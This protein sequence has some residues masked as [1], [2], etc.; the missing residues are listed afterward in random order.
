M[1]KNID[2]KIIII[3]LYDSNY[4][5]HKNIFYLDKDFDI[6]PD[7]NCDNLLKTWEIA[8]K[9]DN[10]IVT[11]CGASW[12]FFDKEI[13]TIPNILYFHIND[14]YTI[15]YERRLNDGINL[16]T[17]K[18]KKIINSLHANLLLL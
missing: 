13:E 11:T 1:L 10:I 15:D 7:S 4:P 2:N 5:V 17:K 18:K 9:C 16:F 6:K 8:K 3:P 12:L 14:N